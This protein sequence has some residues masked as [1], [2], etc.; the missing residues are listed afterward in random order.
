MQSKVCEAAIWRTCG[1]DKTLTGKRMTYDL[2]SFTQDGETS[3]S[4]LSQ[5]I[6]LMADL[7]L[8]TENIVRPFQPLIIAIS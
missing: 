8:G 5:A 7:D 1:N 4:F 2:C 6:G 3:I